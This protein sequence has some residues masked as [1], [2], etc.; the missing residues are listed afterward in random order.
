MALS[1][2]PPIPFVGD[3]GRPVTGDLR[4][5]PA[6]GVSLGA[7]RIDGGGDL[8]R[9][10][11]LSERVVVLE[12]RLLVALMRIELA[13]DGDAERALSGGGLAVPSVST[14]DSLDMPGI[15]NRPTS[16]P[17]SVES[18]CERRYAAE[19]T[20]LSAVCL[21]QFGS[22]EANDCA[23]CVLESS[24]ASSFAGSGVARGER[25]AFSAASI[26]RGLRPLLDLGRCCHERVPDR[27]RGRDEPLL[28]SAMMAVS[29]VCGG[30]AGLFLLSGG[31]VDNF[32]GEMERARSA[33]IEGQRVRS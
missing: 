12:Y 5:E 20:P 33:R 25:A 26:E 2:N 15:L 3:G 28:L 30:G 29:E 31:G 7:S 16:A 8:M 14:V 18:S 1:T 9:I 23:I 22:L 24:G 17:P 27:E 10:D 21:N 11:P 4:S 32:S 6:V 13:L 19:P